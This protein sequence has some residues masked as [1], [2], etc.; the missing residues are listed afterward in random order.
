MELP[1]GELAWDTLPGELWGIVFCYS[2]SEEFLAMSL[3]CK[4]LKQLV[5]PFLYAKFSWIPENDDHLPRVSD[6]DG[7][8]ISHCTKS[9]RRVWE[10]GFHP[11]GPPPYRLLKTLL[12]RP[13]LCGYIREVELLMV[14]PETG[15]F[16]D[17]IEAREAGFSQATLDMCEGYYFADWSV[18]HCPHRGHVWLMYYMNVGRL[19][20]YMAYLLVI[21]RKMRVL[22]L[23]LQGPVENHLMI[24]ALLN[25]PEPFSIEV[26]KFTANPIPRLIGSGRPAR[27]RS[28]V[29]RAMRSI[30]S[31]STEFKTEILSIEELVAWKKPLLD[32]YSA[33]KTLSLPDS[34]IGEVYMAALLTA[35]PHIEHFDCVLG[36][37]SR[38]AHE[39]CDGK[40]VN[41]GL[42][43]VQNTLVSLSIKIK[44][45][46]P[47]SDSIWEPL[48]P[49]GSLKNFKKMR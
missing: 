1:T 46:G 41:Q 25:H 20:A 13:E 10:S 37:D 24:N 23:R 35:L 12:F 38:L 21:L 47:I 3:V 7:A 22:N 31:L 29:C 36:Y 33:I 9:R 8:T 39:F 30:L 17:R 27:K 34:D 2:S 40:I 18:P 28:E 4:R 48:N 45:I 16:R 14:S 42:S 6:L 32:S 44:M 15:V 5:E 43:S 49:V 19:E 11:Y 26:L